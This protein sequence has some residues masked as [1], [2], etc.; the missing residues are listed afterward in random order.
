MKMTD[1][2][3]MQ[4]LWLFSQEEFDAMSGEDKQKLVEIMQEEFKAQMKEAIQSPEK[5]P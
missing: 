1:A 3:K 5:T 4:Y 2:Q